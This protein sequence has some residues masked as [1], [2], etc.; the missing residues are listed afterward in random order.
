MALKLNRRQDADPSNVNEPFVPYRLPRLYTYGGRDYGT[1]A[2]RVPRK[3]AMKA[4]YDQAVQAMRQRHTEDTAAALRSDG[5]VPAP[6]TA[7]DIPTFAET[8]G[9]ETEAEQNDII[10]EAIA[11]QGGNWSGKPGDAGKP[12]ERK[13]PEPKAEIK[14]GETPAPEGG[15]SG[16]LPEDFPHLSRLKKAGVSTYEA[17]AESGGDYSRID[18]IGDGRAEDIEAALKG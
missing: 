11:E 5:D 9:K 14:L 13:Q 3:L 6:L 15:P 10:A 2:A 16:A 17:L 4:I 8:F 12:A 18:G 7:A 1:D